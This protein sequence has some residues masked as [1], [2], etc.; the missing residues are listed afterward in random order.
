MRWT[1]LHIF[2]FDDILISPDAIACLGDNCFKYSLLPPLSTVILRDEQEA[3]HAVK[4][5]FI[6]LVTITVF[7]HFNSPGVSIIFFLKRNVTLHF[8]LS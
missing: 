3:G 6:T 5:H 4:K 1:L 2:S 8:D 7:L